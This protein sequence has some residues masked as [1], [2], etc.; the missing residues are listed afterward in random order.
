ML[1]QQWTGRGVHTLHHVSASSE[2]C[3]NWSGV[4]PAL[5]CS[6][7]HTADS[8]LV[9]CNSYGARSFTPPACSTH[10]IPLAV[11]VYVGNYEYDADERELE[12]TVEKFGPVKNMEFKSGRHHA[13]SILLPAPTL[14]APS[15]RLRIFCLASIGSIR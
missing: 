5:V 4:A 11:Q 13:H 8:H 15:P 12:R 1:I 3:T 7:I 14:A 2:Y 6:A 9:S 10:G